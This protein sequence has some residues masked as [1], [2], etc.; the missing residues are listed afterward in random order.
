M[1]DES[2][3]CAGNDRVALCDFC[4]IVSTLL[5]RISLWFL[6][7]LVNITSSAGFAFVRLQKVVKAELRHHDLLLSRIIIIHIDAQRECEQISTMYEFSKDL[8]TCVIVRG[9]CFLVN[10][11]PIGL[12]RFSRFLRS[13]LQY[14]WSRSTPCISVPSPMTKVQGRVIM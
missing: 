2:Y 4:F 7:V 6:L 11:R 10:S 8:T 14:Q 13:R 9:T 3:R 5:D 1:W 12:P